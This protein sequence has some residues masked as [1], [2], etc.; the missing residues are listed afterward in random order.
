[1]ASRPANGN[2]FSAF[3]RRETDPLEKETVKTLP[4]I[5]AVTILATSPL[6]AQLV[7]DGA[8][9]T[10]LNETNS[11]TGDVTVG[12]NLSLTL[13]VLSDNALLTNSANFF[14]FPMTAPQT[15]INGEGKLEFQFTSPDN[16]SFFCLE[17]R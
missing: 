16:A 13:L 3:A 10:M 1:M 5:L 15:T 14:P 6:R 8:T 9:R 7:A 11:F 17:A 2:A 12:T 4:T